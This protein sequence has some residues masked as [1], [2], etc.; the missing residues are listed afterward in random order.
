MSKCN[1]AIRQK[2]KKCNYASVCLQLPLITNLFVFPVLCLQLP[3]KHQLGFCKQQEEDPTRMATLGGI[4]DSSASS[5]NSAE[6]DSLARFAVDQHNNKEVLL[7]STLSLKHSLYVSSSCF[8]FFYVYS[9]ML[10]FY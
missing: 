10:G 3:N 2:K 4:K 9:Y 8:I 1:Y 6:L 7:Y 5:Q